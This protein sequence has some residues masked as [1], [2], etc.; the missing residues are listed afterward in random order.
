MDIPPTDFSALTDLFEAGLKQERERNGFN[1]SAKEASTV[2]KLTPGSIGSYSSSASKVPASAEPVL[3]KDSKDIWNDEEVE[4][5]IVDV[6]DLWLQPEYTV[7][8]RQKVTS[9]DMFLQMSGKT[10]GIH[11]SDDL[12]VN[13]LLPG[14]EF[15]D[16]ELTVTEQTLEVRCPKYKL[17]FHFPRDVKESEGSAKWDRSKAQLTVTVPVKPLF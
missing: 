13:V 16:I 3:K 4:D 15:K 11:D 7:T 5:S 6:S 10:P 1:S 2:Q 12:I 9:E 17:L 14:T 8:Y